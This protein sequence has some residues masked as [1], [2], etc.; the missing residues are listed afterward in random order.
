[1][2]FYDEGIYDSL[3]GLLAPAYFYESTTRLML[4]AERAHQPVSLIS[5]R[6]DGLNDDQ[7]LKCARDLTAELRGGDLLARIGEKVFVLA[8]LGDHLGAEQLIFRLR[9]TIKPELQFASTFMHL[10]E[11]I[12]RGLSRLAI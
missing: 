4:W 10:G 5:I 11:S 3:T 6:L 2:P 7:I 9:N 1:M 8:L 12:E